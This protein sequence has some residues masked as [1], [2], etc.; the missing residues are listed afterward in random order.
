MLNSKMYMSDILI[1]F[2]NTNDPY[3][4][5]ALEEY[6]FQSLSTSYA[7]IL[8]LWKNENSVIVGRNQNVRNECNIE[9]VMQYN[10]KLVRRKTG[11]GAVF[12]DLGNLNFSIITPKEDYNVQRSIRIIV[13]ALSRVGAN[14]IYSGR[15]DLIWKERKISG[16][17]YLSN[18]HCGLHHGTILMNTDLKI[19]GDVLNVTSEKLEPKGISSVKQRVVNLSEYIQEVSEDD[20]RKSIVM[21]FIKE[22]GERKKVLFMSEEQIEEIY[23]N[24]RLEELIAEYSSEEW[25]WGENFNFNKVF[26]KSFSW[27]QCEVRLLVNHHK[28][29]RIKIYTDSLFPKLIVKLEKFVL[30]NDVVKEVQCKRLSAEIETENMGVCKDILSMIYSEVYRGE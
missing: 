1:I 12:H 20:L 22:Y 4:N 25:I 3:R 19:M 2:T 29:N 5:L 10:T 28:V 17:A 13:R 9:M 21:E 14:T 15:N 23:S 11:G 7:Y 24:E 18:H 30:E 27:G 8:L 16:S 6:A 26:R